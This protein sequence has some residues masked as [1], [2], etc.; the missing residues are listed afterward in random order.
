M[1]DQ[2]LANAIIYLRVSTKEQALRG[3]E[4]E[5][6]SIPAQRAACKRKAESLGAQVIAEF[7]DAGESAKTSAR[8]QLRSM[9]NKLSE[10]GIQYVVVHKVDRLA[11][12]R[13]DDVIINLAIT[14]AGAKLVSV[15]E[16]ID[17]T[18]SGHL[19]HGIMSSLAEFYSQNLAT[20]ALKGMTQKVQR[21]G[22]VFATPIGYKNVANT[23]DGQIIKTVEVDQERFNLMHYAFEEYATGNQSLSTLA[24]ILEA[25]GLTYHRPSL[26]KP[27]RSV[28]A[29]QLQRLLRNKYYVGKIAWNGMEYQGSHMPLVDEGVFN[30]VQD[31]LTNRARSSERSYRTTHY[32]KGSLKC[33]KCDSTIT[34]AVSTGRHGVAYPYFFCIGRHEKYTD[35]DLPSI[36]Q[37]L[38]EKAVDKQYKTEPMSHKDV[39]ELKEQLLHDLKIYQQKG[40]KEKHILKARIKKL[41]DERYLWADKAMEGAIPND[42]AREKQ[43]NL[44]K[45]LE[46]ANKELKGYTVS[47]T[48]L[49][50]LID[51]SLDLA[52]NCGNSYRI[53]ES[54]TTKQGINRSLFEYFEV[55]TNSTNKKQ[56]IIYARRKPVFELLKTAHYSW[57]DDFNL[58]ETLANEELH[59]ALDD[60]YIVFSLL[61][62]SRVAT[63][64]VLSVHYRNQTAREPQPIYS[65][66]ELTL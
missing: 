47:I 42:I 23:A 22:T 6:Y 25:K 28:T 38:I 53:A 36:Q 64:E 32:L 46:Q 31:M 45:Q 12:N 15:T 49:E 30:K 16:N 62:G 19:L 63:L 4:T 61:Y 57:A 65:N 3:G 5:G 56:P 1:N 54:T 18:P 11:R 10:G 66:Y 7:V 24:D 9:L 8:P 29:K 58:T 44:A 34:F 59:R 41:N 17:E 39:L 52:K 60:G 51:R 50:E 14:K 2:L 33:K 26:G 21:G 48:K 55:D 40:G 13:A 27:E 35:C 20:E 37:H 43:D